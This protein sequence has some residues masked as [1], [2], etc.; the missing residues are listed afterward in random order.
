MAPK[1]RG[2]GSDHEDVDAPGPG[3]VDLSS[4]GTGKEGANEDRPPHL[5][6]PQHHPVRS[7][8]Q[9]GHADDGVAARLHR[10]VQRGGAHHASIHVVA[11]VD[12]HRWEDSRYRDR[13]KHRVRIR[14]RRSPR[15]P[16]CDASALVEIRCAEVDVLFGPLVRKVVAQPLPRAVGRVQ[17][18]RKESPQRRPRLPPSSRNS[19]IA[20]RRSGG[21]GGTHTSAKALGPG[22]RQRHKDVSFLPTLGREVLGGGRMPSVR[23]VVEVLCGPPGSQICPQD[24]PGARADDQVELGWVDAPV[25]QRLERAGVVGHPNQAPASQNKSPFHRPRGYLCRLARNPRRPA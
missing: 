25:V 10:E 22:S 24:G 6:I 21:K 16:E 11:T 13:G 9:G 12:L 7:K 1:L 18:G 8:A 3:V 19:Q 5:R 23:V 17:P 14:R 2:P 15:T 20:P 4:Q